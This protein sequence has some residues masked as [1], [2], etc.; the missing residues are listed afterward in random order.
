LTRHIIFIKNEHLCILNMS[1]PESVFSFVDYKAYL[2]SVLD[3]PGNERGYQSRL[4]EAAGCQRSYLS[5]VVRSAPHLTPEHAMGMAQ[6]WK[7]STEETDYFLD[8][9]HLGRT[10]SKPLRHRLQERMKETRAKRANLASRYQ[11][12]HL[13]PGEREQI[14]Y[15]SWHLAA[16]HILTS[17]PTHQTES[18]LAE[19]L[20][21]PAS[22]VRKSLERLESL[23]LV[24]KEGSKWR[25]GTGKLHLP[26]SSLLNGVNHS[27][28]RM[29]A[30]WDS[31]NPDSEGIHYTVVH[32]HSRKDLETL[33]QKILG[34][35]D[36]SREV[37]DPSPSEEV[38]CLCLDLF[39]V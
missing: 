9:V 25:F 36:E 6:F 23:G 17:V 13:E 12:K 3:G 37:V 33:K 2:K 26:K 24:A 8:L 31:Q 22:F 32:S 15:S 27:N 30:V 14:Y 34:W 28:W 7:L 20:S 11:D 29:R 16:L 39:P 38:T 18:A 35:I 21:L 4:A 19:R 5:Q 1:K 10:H